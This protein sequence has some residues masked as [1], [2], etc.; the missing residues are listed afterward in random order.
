VKSKIKW[1][2]LPKTEAGITKAIKK[3]IILK[4]FDGDILLIGKDTKSINFNVVEFYC[5]KA[6]SS[7]EI[8]DIIN[9]MVLTEQ[10][11]IEVLKEMDERDKRFDCG[12]EE[13]K[14][15]N[16]SWKESLT[17]NS[18]DA[19][20]ERTVN[21]DMIKATNE[22]I[23]FDFINKYLSKND[24]ITKFDLQKAFVF[25]K[26]LND[27]QKILDEFFKFYEEEIS[28]GEIRY[29][30]YFKKPIDSEKEAKEQEEEKKIIEQWRIQ[31]EKE[32]K[33]E[34]KQLKKDEKET[35]K[36]LK[37]VDK[38]VKKGKKKTN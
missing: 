24:N 37:R 16:L 30:V 22:I 17:I 32:I 25:K 27:C 29:K 10:I 12:N 7:F 21:D 2:K 19:R 28:C 4:T 11:K 38:I 3:N 36:V 1:V 20:K 6:K 15:Y 26:D 5:D 14:D 8:T 18:E 9:N 34:K 23:Y 13:Y 33:E 31:F 35:M